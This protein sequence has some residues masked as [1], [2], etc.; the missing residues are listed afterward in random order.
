MI[1]MIIYVGMII[2]IKRRYAVS[3]NKTEAPFQFCSLF[4]FTHRMTW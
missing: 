2:M 3:I 1:T 4:L